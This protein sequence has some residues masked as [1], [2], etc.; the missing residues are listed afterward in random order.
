M[1]LFISNI[2]D[3]PN[4]VNSQGITQVLSLVEP[5]TNINYGRNWTD[6]DNREPQIC[7]INM[8]D[9]E[10]ADH[11]LSPNDKHVF[12]LITFSNTLVDEDKVLVHCHAGISRSTA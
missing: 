4:I 10:H 3:V 9:R 7:R 12:D 5:W 2:F 11:Y 1:N 6:N 8:V